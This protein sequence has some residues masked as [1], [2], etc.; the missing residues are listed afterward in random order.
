MI[1]WAVLLRVVGLA[2]GIECHSK[3]RCVG[4]NDPSAKLEV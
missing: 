4:R 3:S 1:R 2:A